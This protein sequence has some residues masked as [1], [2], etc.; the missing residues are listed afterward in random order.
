MNVRLRR[1]PL[2]KASI[3]GSTVQSGDATFPN[4]WWP[5]SALSWIG[6]AFLVAVGLTV[7]VLATF[8]TG[9]RGTAVALRVTA[10]WSFVL[11]WAA[12]AGAAVSRL[13]GP[14]V[15]GLARRGREIGL[16]YASAQLVHISLVV[17]LLYIGGGPTGRMI[18][19]WVGIFFT[20]VLAMLSLPRLHHLLGERLW[21]LVL[22]VGL[23]YIALVFAM[24][25]IIIPLQVRG[26]ASYP[27]AYIPFDLM[28]V[29]GTAFRFIAFARRYLPAVG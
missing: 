11:F 22:N 16:A 25:F 5:G 8:G 10:R 19:F 27:V 24:D 3:L 20:Y 1:V 9:S 14:W 29:A 17:W 21:R 13:F 18:F 7:P 12:Y 6:L 15:A 28:L 2:A 23:E 26:F 4:S